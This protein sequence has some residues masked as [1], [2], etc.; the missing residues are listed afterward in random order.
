[1]ENSEDLK[2]WAIP[3]D[4]YSIN[5]ENSTLEI[6]SDSGTGSLKINYD[7]LTMSSFAIMVYLLACV[8]TD[9]FIGRFYVLCYKK[10]DRLK[11]YQ[12]VAILVGAQLL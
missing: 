6:L 4:S 3:V 5:C 1:M 8:V 12:L 2:L 9:I 7:T 11:F 10:D